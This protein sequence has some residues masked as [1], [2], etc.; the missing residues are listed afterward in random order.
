MAPYSRPGPDE[1]APFYAGYVAAVP[2]GDVLALLERQTDDVLAL[3]QSL[4]PRRW[5]HR[6]A[7]GK[8]SVA[9]VLGHLCDAERVLGYRALR[10]ARDD[11]TELPGFDEN[12][13]V[14]TAEFDARTPA[15]LLAE[16]VAV[17]RATVALF[18]GLPPSAGARRGVANGSPVTVRALLYIV[19]GHERHHLRVLRERYLEE[20]GPDGTFRQNKATPGGPP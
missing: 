1:Y 7:A 8:W 16:Y 5:R 18:R 3:L 10:F 12:A 2:E 17:R 15:S 4:E 19:T 11:H 13:W 14:P 6:Y 9:E 20:R